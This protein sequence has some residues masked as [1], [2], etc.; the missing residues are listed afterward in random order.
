MHFRNFCRVPPLR[1]FCLMPHSSTSHRF[2]SP[3]PPPPN[4]TPRRPDSPISHPMIWNLRN[5]AESG[6]ARISGN[7]KRIMGGPVYH[8]GQF[9][10]PEIRRPLAGSA[11][12]QTPRGPDSAPP[13]F[14]PRVPDSPREPPDSNPMV[15]NLRHLAKSGNSR[16][17]GNSEISKFRGFPAISGDGARIGRLP[18]GIRSPGGS[19]CGG[20]R[21]GPRGV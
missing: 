7:P 3:H 16:L 21:S 6:N 10:T 2:N 8:R 1:I 4:T 17:P 19:N 14:G 12:T 5:L 20:A 11:R 18:H 15:R 13:Q 9:S